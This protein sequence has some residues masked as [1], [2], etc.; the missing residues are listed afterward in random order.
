MKS[1]HTVRQMV[2]TIFHAANRSA[3]VVSDLRKFTRSAVHLTKE[4]V[5][6]KDSVSTVLRVLSSNLRGN[7]EIHLDFEQDLCVS[8]IPRDLFQIWSNVLK[9]AFEAI[10]EVP[11]DVWIRSFSRDGHTIV[12]FEN[13]GP[14]IPKELLPG[15]FERFKSS[16]GKENSGFGLNIVKRILETNNWDVMVSS[17]T[18]RTIFEFTL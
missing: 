9:N 17:D 4:C 12:Q 11:G 6:I 16:K 7:I 1:I 5:Q 15:V 8:A 10:G 18:E 3:D 14:A 13:N 2:D